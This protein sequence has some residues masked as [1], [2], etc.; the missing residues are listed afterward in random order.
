MITLGKTIAIG[1]DGYTN[2]TAVVSTINGKS[3]YALLNDDD[4]GDLYY[5][6]NRLLGKKDKTNE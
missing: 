6:T 2:N 3:K 4:D 5:K 1:L